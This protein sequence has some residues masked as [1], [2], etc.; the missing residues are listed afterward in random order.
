MNLSK[1]RVWT[2]LLVAGMAVRALA[3]ETPL[4]QIGAVDEKSDE[5]VEYKAAAQHIEIAA[6]Q[7]QTELAAAAGK[8]LHGAAHPQLEIAYHLDAPPPH[9]E[10]FS[11]KLLHATKNGPQMAVFSNGLMAGLIQLWG[12]AETGSSH[13]WKKTYRL[14]IRASCSWPAAMC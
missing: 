12:T 13:Q 1:A 5:F 7:R 11:F 10:L 4:W 6:G 2:I 3:A 8:G 9:G 14:Y